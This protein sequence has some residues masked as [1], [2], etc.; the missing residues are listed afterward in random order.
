MITYQLEYRDLNTDDGWQRW[1]SPPM[2]KQVAEQ[3]KMS[4]QIV[5]V[6]DSLTW[7]FRII[8]TADKQD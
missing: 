3:L 4:A 1:S 5:A 6:R 2:P 7:D 8:P